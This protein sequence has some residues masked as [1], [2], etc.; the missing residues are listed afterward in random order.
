MWK[1]TFWA[2]LS[3]VFIATSATAQWSEL[4]SESFQYKYEMDVTPDLEDVDSNDTPDFSGSGGTAAAGILSVAGGS[5]AFYYSATDTNQIWPG[6]FDSTTGYTIEFKVKIN[7]DLGSAT[8]NAMGV[9]ASPADTSAW[10]FLGVGAEG[11]SWNESVN[12]SSLGPPVNNTDGFHVFRVAQKPGVNEYC[13]WRDDVL[14]ARDI[15]IGYDYPIDRIAFGDIGGAWDGAYD[16]D[17]FR[18]TPGGHTPVGFEFPEVGPPS[19]T[20]AS[21]DFAYK[22]E[23]DADPRDPGAIDLDSN[24]AADFAL[25]GEETALTFPGSG[26]AQIATNESVVATY[27]ESGIS[28]PA[29]V[30]PTEG[31]SGADGFTVETRFKI[32]EDTGSVGAFDIVMCPADNNELTV[33]TVGDDGQYWYPASTPVG[34]P[35][36]N[37]DDFHTLRIVRTSDAAGGMYYIYRDD[38]VLTEEGI[39][40]SASYI[41]NALYLGDTGGSDQGIVEYDYLRFTQGAYAPDAGSGGLDGD[42]DGDGYVGSSD[43]DIVRA[44]WGTAVTPGDLSVGD[45][46]GSGMIGSGDLD[47]V[48]ANWGATTSAAVPEPSWFVLLLGGM[49]VAWWRRNEL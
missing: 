48:R 41:R 31:L 15:G 43:L 6:K 22:Y 17:Y 23:M 47:I 32:I 44:N 2:L 13:V 1:Q 8:G 25:T 14:I 5:G 38:V 20:K 45:A 28:D 11:Q 37:T 7:E 30:W 3:A 35:A 4:D 16:V 39:A 42:L 29:A 40:A 19:E 10:T 26:T 18:F 36:D 33:L 9:I 12:W 24:G 46:D 27:F 34:E 49:L 21:A